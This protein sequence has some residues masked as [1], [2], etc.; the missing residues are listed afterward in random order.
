MAIFQYKAKNKKAETVFGKIEAESKEDA[1]EKITHFDLIPV[2]IEEDVLAGPAASQRGRR[3]RF[4]RIRHKELYLFSRQFASLLKAG[5]AILRALQVLARQT[6]N[7][8]FQQVI[9]QIA[10]DVRGG[11]SFSDSIAAY[12]NIFPSIYIN[13]SRAGEEGGRIQD[14]MAKVADYLQAQMDIRGKV[15][16]ALV[17]PMMMLMCG[18]GATIFILTSVMPKITR[19]FLDTRQA[20]PK[21][22]VIIMWTSD[23]LIQYW[24]WLA[25]VILVVVF[26]MK[27]WFKTKSGEEFFYTAM[28][29]MPVWG[30]IWLKEDLA[31][32]SRTMAVLVESGI[33]IITAMNLSIQTVSNIF[34][35]EQLRRCQEG[36][37]AGRS[38]GDEIRQMSLIP[39]VMGDLIAVG[40]EAGSLAPSLADV[41]DNYEREIHDAIKVMTTLFEPIMILV[42]GAVIGFIVIAMLLPIFQ[43]DIFAR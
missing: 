16:M 9:D 41:A 11:K 32:F 39:D 2:L 40:E 25:L 28:L 26:L 13:M 35:Q 4:G 31:R 34:L 36:M 18:I 33:P 7:A 27:Q 42:V 14:A 29:K 6:K 38:L 43:M 15:K 1:V 21:S 23:F 8:Y 3:V 20:L 12:P 22:T 17:Y 37:I 10:A 24:A 30:D 5:I 19:I